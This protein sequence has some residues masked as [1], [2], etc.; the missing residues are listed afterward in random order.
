MKGRRS[1]YVRHTYGRGPA[2]TS[3]ASVRPPLAVSPVI[4]VMPA[5]MLTVPNPGSPSDWAV[6]RVE[7][8]HYM[9]PCKLGRDYLVLVFVCAIATQIPRKRSKAVKQ[10]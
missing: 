5:C 10:H 8:V 4:A 2:F 3:F 1:Y 9:W 6:H 7:G